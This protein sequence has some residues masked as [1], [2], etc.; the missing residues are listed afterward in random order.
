M[1]KQAKATEIKAKFS[2]DTEEA[3][4]KISELGKRVDS[5]LVKI[6]R[7][8]QIEGKEKGV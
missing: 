1:T 5:I 6:E 4:L 8:A 7:I 2:L 3:E